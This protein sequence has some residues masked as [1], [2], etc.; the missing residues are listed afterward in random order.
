MRRLRLAVSSLALAALL[1]V[2]AA[3]PALAAD[4]RRSIDIRFPTSTSA[5]YS[6]DYGAARSGGRVHR[7]TDL[8]GAS[9]WAV[10]AAAS[11]RV[12]WMPRTEQRSAGFGLQIRDSAG[13]TFAY[14]HLGPAGGSLREAVSSGIDEGDYVRRGQLI[15]RLG[16][17]GNA[18]GGTPH[19]HFEIHDPAVRDPFGGTRLN[20][21]ASLRRAQGLLAPRST[22]PP[23]PSTRSI[24]A[25]LR[26][27][28]RGP[29]VARWQRQLNTV[30]Q[31]GLVA[32]G[33]FGDGTHAATVR[34]QRS[35]GIGPD[36]A[37]TVGP[38]T[39]AAMARRLRAA[40]AAS[41]GD[42]PAPAATALRLGS[43]GPAV[44]RWQRNLNRV[45]RAGLTADGAFGPATHR[46]TVRFQRSAD[47]GP[48]GL[49]TVGPRTR[50]EMARRLRLGAPTTAPTTA[51]SSL[52]RQGDRGPAVATW[53]RQLNRA[54][55]AGLIADGA[56]GPA[57]HRAT[58]RFQRSA[59]LTADGV[60]GRQTRAA[61]QRRL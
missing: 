19:L 24:S 39:R 52:L 41:R 55:R 7:A 11:G 10:Y 36:G 56:F 45:T 30:M 33:V 38:R 47:L 3:V 18:A 37:G 32:D 22:T 26:R 60:V 48:D 21:Y 8:F 50:A 27:G 12:V 44:V 35:V 31:A 59:G 16:D 9:G 14:Y 61:M 34:F 13:R 42:R 57:T 2:G 25:P 51:R 46:A 6:N 29:A 43:R 1:V 53:Q 28:S 49:G 58:V 15:G 5:R 4:Y 20:P 54:L 23:A 17:S 40:P